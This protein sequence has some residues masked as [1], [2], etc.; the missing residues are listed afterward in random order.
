MPPQSLYHSL[1]N[2]TIESLLEPLDSLGTVDAVAGAD[3]A[4]CAAATG[5]SLARSGHA[6]VKV[7]AVDT[8]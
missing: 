3:D 8:D 7:H 4:L 5:N 6:A 1:S 2:D